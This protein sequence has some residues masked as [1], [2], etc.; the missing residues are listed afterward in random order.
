[1]GNTVSILEKQGIKANTT[2]DPDIDKKIEALSNKP[3]DSLASIWKSVN[4]CVL[5]GD[6]EVY[7]P[8]TIEKIAK[9]EENNSYDGLEEWIG[10]SV[11]RIGEIWSCTDSVTRI[12]E[13]CSGEHTG[14]LLAFCY[15]TLRVVHTEKTTKDLLSVIDTIDF[16]ED[17]DCSGQIYRAI[18]DPKNK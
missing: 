7:P 14:Q 5:N 4:S 17:D 6:I 8:C 1:M 15:S 9:N 16:V 12:V 3:S 13:I 18:F 2:V 11:F 10:T